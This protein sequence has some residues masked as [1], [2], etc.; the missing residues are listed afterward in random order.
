MARCLIN[1]LVP[2][3]V[4]PETE[5]ELLIKKWKWKVKSVQKENMERHS[6]WCDIELKLAVARTMKDEEGFYYPHNLDFRR[7]AYPMHSY[8]IRLGSDLCHGILEIALRV[9]LLESQA[10]AG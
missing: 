8:L 3:A 5:D 10:Y 7:R 2:V 9:V 1:S 6:L 4:R